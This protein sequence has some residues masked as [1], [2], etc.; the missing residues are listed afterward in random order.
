VR[1]LL[2]LPPKRLFLEGLKKRKQFRLILKYI[3][4]D[5][6][7]KGKHRAIGTTVDPIDEYLDIY[8]DPNLY[9]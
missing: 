1:R 8:V 4:Q 9:K 2:K 3:D 6:V 7:P 5:P